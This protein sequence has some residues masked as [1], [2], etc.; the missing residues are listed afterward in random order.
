MKKIKLF[1]VMIFSTM[2]FLS[3]SVVNAIDMLP[4]NAAKISNCEI[5]QIKTGT[6]PWDEDDL[7]GNDSSED[8]YIVRSFDQV[9]WTIENT[10]IT[11]DGAEKYTGG[12]I[13]FEVTVPSDQF[14]VQTFKWDLDSM[15]WIENPKVSADGLV[16]TGYYSMKTND[17]TVPGKQNLIFVAKVLGAKNGATLDPEFKMWLNGNKD[18]YKCV[19]HFTPIT[20]SAAAKY[21]VVMKRNNYVDDR[22]T[23]TINDEEISG[24]M[25]GY[26]LVYQLYNENSSK[27]LKGIEYPS[28]VVKNDVK[29]TLYK[30]DNNTKEL[31]DITAVNTPILWQYYVAGTGNKKSNGYIDGRDIY[32]GKDSIIYNG[33]ST[34]PFGNLKTIK[35]R[36]V[37]ILDT[38]TPSMIQDKNII[39]TSISGYKF[40]G[41]FPTFDYGDN[42]TSLA[43]KYGDNIGCFGS[44]QFQV[45][46]PDFDEYDSSSSYYLYVSDENM[47]A[48]SESGINVTEQ[49]KVT[50][51]TSSVQYVKNK[52][53]SYGSNI[54]IY[55]RKDNSIQGN[56]AT[57]WNAG[58]SRVYRGQQLFIRADVSQKASNEESEYP[59]TIN[60]FI[61]YD[62][63]CY[64]TVVLQNGDK[65][66]ISNTE[67]EFKMWYATKKD[68]SNWSSDLE[69]NRAK[70]EEMNLY[71]TLEEVPEGYKVVGVYLESIDGIMKNATTSFYVPVVVRET[72]NINKTYA[73]N[74]YVQLFKDGLDRTTQ[75]VKNPDNIWPKAVFTRYVDYIKTEYDDGG[76][77]ISGT[78]YKSCEWGNT[79]LVVGAQ[80]SITIEAMDPSTGSKKTSYDMSKNEYNVT[81]KVTPA[82]KNPV[83]ESTLGESDVTVNAVVTLPK[84]M[85]YVAGSSNYGDPDLVENADGTITLTWTIYNCTVNKKIEPVIFEGHINEENSNGTQLV[86]NAEINADVSKIGPT[87]YEDRIAQTSVQV[88]DLAAHRLYKTVE[89]PVIEKNGDIHYSISYKNNTDEVISDF[90][91]LDILPYNGDSRGTSFSG[92]YKVT[93]IVIKQ[94]DE[95]GDVLSSNENLKLYCTTDE[96][97]RNA[98][99]KDENL[100]DGWTLTETQSIM[101]TLTA[102]A[103]KGEVGTQ[104]LVSVD[105]YMT[106][107][108]NKS[109][110]KYVN[111]ASTQVYSTTNAIVTSDVIAQIVSRKIEGIVWY[112][113][114]YNGIMDD[115][116][117]RVSNV[118]MIL[119]D[120]EGNSVTDVDGNVVSELTTDENGYYCFKS[121]RASD[122]YVKIVMPESKYTLTEKEVGMKATVNSKFNQENETT[123]LITKLNSKALPNLIV[124]NQN[125]GLIKKQ[126]KVVVNYKEDETDRK[127]YDEITIDGR[128][129]DE[130]TTEDKIDEINTANNNEYEF[131]RVEG[132]TT[133]NMTEDVI[134]VTYYYK[135]IKG[136]VTITKV[137]KDNTSK[138]LQGAVF[139]IEKLDDNGNIDT[140]FKSIEKT[141]SS[142]GIAVF[143]ELIIGKYRI[144]EIKAPNGYEL[145]QSSI[146]V[147]IDKDNREMSYTLVNKKKL[148]LP[149]TGGKNFII[150]T[151][152]VGLVTIG[153]SLVLNKK[154][155]KN[156]A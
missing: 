105:I 109:D 76:I 111:S 136:S 102:F 135:K 4:D 53:G 117:Q 6:A 56:A 62:A 98:T 83:N 16:L 90:Q 132:N 25:F 116:E 107:S 14:S 34:M 2:L 87:R 120:G 86:T 94:K 112:D 78:H 140:T 137:D 126:T 142:S 65:N 11:T 139:K 35:D 63:D 143:D 152:I 108:G 33:S 64:E 37:C 54:Y 57:Y 146:D 41:I 61:K 43:V 32:Q 148:D 20:I 104:G 82:L 88:I 150:Y 51:D 13:Y 121:L 125:A 7:A 81:Y 130:Y 114:N 128:V 60:N 95:N 133:G 15:A 141:T 3:F 84:G 46:I 23:L 55:K 80:Q 151:S 71:E 66:Y 96:T 18:E 29:F 154:K 48:T 155:V 1:M 27:G 24:R 145:L 127:L 156:K 103:L 119:T 149:D 134:Y 19:R 17:T 118:K 113:T 106:T 124:T 21:N 72:A 44:I 9:T 5:K 12:K 50:D 45:F 147:E 122:Y 91:L 8:N 40:D 131:V 101:S 68:G 31:V 36:K 153:V 100:G 93:K 67:M 26:A 85:T 42:T 10:M 58:D 74:Q 77:Q 47:E 110:D 123:D 144:T 115:D 97:A 70:Q 52:I 99:A 28:G 49:Q 73:A 129:D 22:V 92:T 138:L 69:M 79:A 38:G 89:V 30:K 75:T 39:H 59:R